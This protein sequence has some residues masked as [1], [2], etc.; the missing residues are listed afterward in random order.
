MGNNAPQGAGVSKWTPEMG[1]FYDL[2][3]TDIDGKP[4]D[5]HS[6]SGKILLISNVASACGKTKKHYTG[7]VELQR[8][9]GNRGFQVLAFPCNQFL[10]QE[11]KNEAQIKDFVCTKFKPEPGFQMFSKVNVNGKE[12]SPVFLY[13]KKAFPGEIKWNFSGKWLIDHK[14]VPRSRPGDAPFEEIEKE[15]EALLQERDKDGGHTEASST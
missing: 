5:F 15:I 13:L 11:S 7:L 12:T 8:K 6:F 2:S 4:V 10:Y 3:A 9:F 14:G 1:L